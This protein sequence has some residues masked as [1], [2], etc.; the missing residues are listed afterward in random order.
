MY[1]TAVRLWYDGTLLKGSRYPITCQLATFG[2]IPKGRIHFGEAFFYP[3][4]KYAAL[5]RLLVKEER[6]PV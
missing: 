2:S 6:F 3:K 4:D 5:K 1:F